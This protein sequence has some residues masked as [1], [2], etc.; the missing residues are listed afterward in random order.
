MM[1]LSRFIGPILRSSWVRGR[2]VAA[3]NRRPAG[4]SDAVRATARAQLWGE[5]RD[6]AGQSA[7]A[8]LETPDG[9]T[10]TA[11][12]AVLAA[13]AVL[14]GRALPGFQ[15]PSRA[16]GA[17]FILSVPGTARTDL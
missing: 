1:R 14:E 12:T 6:A 8:R 16:F 4:P 3:I 9:Y 11:K 15:T 7:S 2:L 17:D 10:L 5:V 13:R